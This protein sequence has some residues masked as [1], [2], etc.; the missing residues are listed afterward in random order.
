MVMYPIT[1]RTLLRMYGPCKAG[2]RLESE[3][4]NPIDPLPFAILA[5]SRNRTDQRE[6]KAADLRVG[7]KDEGRSGVKILGKEK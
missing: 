4:R 6:I 2:P 7:K 3:H 5:F 1:P